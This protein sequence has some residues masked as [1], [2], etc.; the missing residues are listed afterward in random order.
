MPKLE[1]IEA[2]SRPASLSLQPRRAPLPFSMQSDQHPYNGQHNWAGAA[3][4]F[5]TPPPTANWSGPP[6][7]AGPN[8]PAVPPG[9]YTQQQ[10]QQQMIM[11]MSMMQQMH[12]PP[13]PPPPLGSKPQAATSDPSRPSIPMDEQKIAQ[14]LFQQTAKGLTYKSAIE[15][16][17]GV[18]SGST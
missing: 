16:M 5:F 3:N 13:P 17:H 6:H 7:L 15:S 4:G 14:V 2:T 18:S 1:G 9:N 11:M 8:H 10:Q 12:A